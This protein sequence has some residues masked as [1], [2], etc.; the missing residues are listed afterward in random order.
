MAVYR[1]MRPW[2][3]LYFFPRCSTRM[4]M[5]DMRVSSA[6]VILRALREFEMAPVLGL[7]R[8]RELLAELCP[9]DPFVWLLVSQALA[10][11]KPLQEGQAF[12]REDAVVS[13]KAV[14]P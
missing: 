6:E 5:L 4:T 8:R 7:L 2:P 11:V 3:S 9:T 14:L 13:L 10:D 12:V 1:A